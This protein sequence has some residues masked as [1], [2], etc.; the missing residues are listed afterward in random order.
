MR[1]IIGLFSNTQRTY[2]RYAETMCQS[3]CFR[4]IF[5]FISLLVK[6]I[7]YTTHQKKKVVAGWQYDACDE[8][9]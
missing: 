9:D 2:V 5:G 1:V 6:A 3:Y 4:N 8:Y 7:T